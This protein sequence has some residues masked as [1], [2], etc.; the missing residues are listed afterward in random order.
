MRGDDNEY[1][2]TAIQEVGKKE[3]VH[4]TIRCVAKGDEVVDVAVSARPVRQWNGDGRPAD[5]VA[6]R[7]TR[8]VQQ[9]MRI[10]T[11]APPRQQPAEVLVK[12]APVP[13]RRRRWYGKGRGAGTHRRRHK[14]MYRVVSE[15]RSGTACGSTGGPSGNVLP[16]QPN[17]VID[18][19]EKASCSC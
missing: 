17:K 9:T 14:N 8:S 11:C 6:R 2:S 12:R 1:E 3:H 16:H 18:V 5:G 7:L 10:S 19:G 13:C 4:D 15:E